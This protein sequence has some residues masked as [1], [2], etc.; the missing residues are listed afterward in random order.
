MVRRVSV[1]FMLRVVERLC[2]IGLLP[3]ATKSQGKSD[4]FEHLAQ[5][6]HQGNQ[7][8]GQNVQRKNAQTRHLARPTIH[9]FLGAIRPA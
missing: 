8:F 6:R 4:V 7:P 9:I 3:N 5:I 2:D 1:I